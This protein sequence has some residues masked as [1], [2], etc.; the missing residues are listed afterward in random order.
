MTQNE[1]A[2]WEKKMKKMLAKVPSDKIEEAWDA[3]ESILK[4]LKAAQTEQ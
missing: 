2:D 3:F 1:I 4:D